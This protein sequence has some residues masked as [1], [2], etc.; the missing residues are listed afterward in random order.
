MR[1]EVLI[2]GRGGQ[3]CHPVSGT[4]SVFTTHGWC[5]LHAYRIDDSVHGTHRRQYADI[6]VL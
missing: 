3:V 1:K 4:G 2:N 5:S 6:A